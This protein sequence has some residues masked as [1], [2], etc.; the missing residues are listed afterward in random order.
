MICVEAVTR[1]AE[2]HLA[3]G[4]SEAGF[5]VPTLSHLLALTDALLAASLAAGKAS[6]RV[7]INDVVGDD[8]LDFKVVDC[9]RSTS[10]A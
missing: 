8:V 6:Q 7:T 10:H 2:V 3:L 5:D 1:P 9:R 4:T